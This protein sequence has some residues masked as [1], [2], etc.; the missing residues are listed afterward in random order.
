MAIQLKHALKTSFYF[1]VNAHTVYYFLF[2]SL[3]LNSSI[4]DRLL[5][6]GAKS[7]CHSYNF[8]KM[9]STLVTM[10]IFLS[11]SICLHCLLTVWRLFTVWIVYF[12]F[13]AHLSSESVDR[14]L[15]YYLKAQ[16]QHK[17]FVNMRSVLVNVI[18]LSLFT[19]LFTLIWLLI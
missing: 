17:T 15:Y 3:P 5:Y 13:N 4:G 8:V 6:N 2:S 14:L 9:R 12:F 19:I 7:Q 1:L 18:V 11:F 16:N 10:I